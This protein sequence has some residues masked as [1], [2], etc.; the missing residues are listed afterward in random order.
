[1][2]AFSLR[3]LCDLIDVYCK[4]TEHTVHVDPS[5]IF[6]S[7]IDFEAG[8]QKL[9]SVKVI[10]LSHEHLSF[11]KP[12]LQLLSENAQPVLIIFFGTDI[13]F[14][15]NDIQDLLDWFPLTRFWITNYIDSHERCEIL[16]LGNSTHDES[17]VNKKSIPLCISYMR[18]HCQERMNLYKLLFCS[19]SLLKYFNPFLEPT[20]YNTLLSK[21]FFSLCPS[22]NGYDTYRFWESL[23]HKSIPIVKQNDFYIA[24]RRQ[25]PK[26]PF[27]CIE[28]W[29]DLISL[30]TTLTADLYESLWNDSDISCCWF[31]FWKSK[32]SVIVNTP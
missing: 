32:L 10:A 23:C 18:P 20:E 1:M 16:P 7:D 4:H 13:S 21:C 31:T 2:K 30:E 19:P 6:S 12:R 28:E 22:G 27:L 26:L 25:Y 15:N 14:N 9:M 11:W 8:F 3:A 29:N 17:I 24:L 5:K